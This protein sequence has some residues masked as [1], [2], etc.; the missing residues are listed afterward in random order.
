M[1]AVYEATDQRFGSTVAL[2]QTLVAGET[3]RRAFE[4]EATL[5]NTLQHAGLPHVIDYFFE[6]EGQFLVMQY[7][8]GD[9]LGQMLKR[10]TEPFPVDDV[11]AWADQLLDLLDYLHTHDPPII[12]RDIKP[13]NLKLTRRGGIILLD[14]GLAK[15]LVEQ[16]AANTTS[17]SIVG[18][19]PH[20]A[21]LEQIRGTGTDA[22]SDLFALAAT[23][24]HLLSK[25]LA[26]DALAR[27]EAYVNQHIDILRPVNE[28]NPA[29]PAAV[30][31]V[32][33]SAL[34]LR[35]EDRFPTAAA[36][37]AR[38]RDAAGSPAGSPRTSGIPRMA[39]TVVAGRST[40]PQTASTMPVADTLPPAAP[41]L[42]PTYPATIAAPLPPSS[43]SG[44]A[45]KIVVALASVA[46]IAV[47]GAAVALIYL[48]GKGVEHD[49][50]STGP[51]ATSQPPAP[52]PAR[53]PE[54]TTPTPAI[55][56]DGSPVPA[57]APSVSATAS[58]EREAMGSTSYG[59]EL[60]LD[61]R[62]GTAWVEGADGPGIGES[63]TV[64]L[65]SAARVS[66]VRVQPGYFKSPALW[67]KNNRVARATLTLSDGRTVTASF[68]DEMRE[69]AVAIGGGPISWITLRI[70]EAYLGGDEIDTAI[71]E[72][73]VDTQ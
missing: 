6:D 34:G 38:L 22:R 51:P 35:R 61:G 21:P 65:S 44:M 29:V 18:Y 28:A 13:E 40:T 67:A 57:A 37:R 71:S 27:A 72:I 55:P 9:D 33:Q 26:P 10:R 49:R 52:T 7:I 53:A 54:A 31:S 5:L 12:H 41:T 50:P 3:L 20:Y 36:M 4:R 42:Q 23:I 59:P 73:A 46:V 62:P 25:Q 1:G 66:R 2:K 11:L 58:S 68:E 32:L 8:P 64:R 47:L 39:D 48:Y 70:D 60:A 24:Y 17:S 43:G 45:A 16:A 19:T 15:G 30:A 56:T 63:I 69:Q 14:F